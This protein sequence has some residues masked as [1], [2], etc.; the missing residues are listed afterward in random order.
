MLVYL[1]SCTEKTYIPKPRGYFN[2]ETPSPEYTKFD[3][4][5]NYTFEVSKYAVMLPAPDAGGKGRCWF[6]IFYPR[7][8][9]TIYLTYDPVE[10]NI[11]KY[12][13]DSHELVYKHVVKSSGID[14]ALITDSAAKVYGMKYKIEG[15]AACPYQFYLTDSVDH[16]FRAALYFN[17]RPNYD[18]L[19]QVLN[20]LEADMDHIIQTFEWKGN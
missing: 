6:N 14:E 10:N 4:A 8:N 5:C 19:Y 1:N 18:S 17:F 12:L 16:F 7:F 3:T 13:D 20:F 2:I 9:A 11:K 15:D